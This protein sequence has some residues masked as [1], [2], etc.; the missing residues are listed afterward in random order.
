MHYNVNLDPEFD[1]AAELE[2]Y[3]SQVAKLSEQGSLPRSVASA[4]A[5]EGNLRQ[6]HQL[7][8]LHTSCSQCPAGKWT[9]LQV[10]WTFCTEWHPDLTG[11]PT[12]APTHPPTPVPTP[13]PDPVSV[14]QPVPLDDDDTSVQPGSQPP[15]G[16]AG[17]CGFYRIDE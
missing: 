5:W 15:R 14:P 7:N 4:T 1:E 6:H 9:A 11:Y 10:G 12:P 16:A 13:Y 3:R 17:V 2:L 8:N